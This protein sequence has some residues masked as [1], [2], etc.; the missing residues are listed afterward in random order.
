MEANETTGGAVRTT[1]GTPIGTVLEGRYQVVRPLARGGMSSVYAGIDLRLD[2][3]VAIK[4]MESTYAADP[5]F[6]ERFNGEARA[7]ARLDHTHVVAVHDQGV[8]R[9]GDTDR[10]YLVM[11]LVD[12][13]TLRDL[14]RAHRALPVPLTMAILEQ[15]LSALADAHA[16]GLVH[17]D[18]KPENVLIGHGSGGGVVKVA[19]FGLVRAIASARST[20]DNVVLGTVAYL[21]PEQL[22]SGFADAHSDVYATGIMCYEMLTGHPPYSADTGLGVAYRHVHDDVPAPSEAVPDIPA[23]LDDLV[24]RATRRDP[25][26]RPADA[27]AF[28]SDL[29]RIRDQLGIDRVPVPVPEWP[30]PNGDPDTEPADASLATVEVI[31]ETI[32]LAKPATAPPTPPADATARVVPT[33]P[34]SAGPRGT[35]AISRAE[36]DAALR[37][38]PPPTNPEPRHAGDGYYEQRAKGRRLSWMW[39]VIILLLAAIIGGVAWWLGIGQW[40]SVPQVAGQDSA[41]AERALTAADLNPQFTQAY[42]NTVPAGRVVGTT[43][44]VGSRALRGAKVTLLVSEGRPVVPDVAPG[45]QVAAVEQAIRSLGLQPKLD[46]NANTYDNTV[47]AGAV[48]KVVPSPGTPVDVGS[49]VTISVSEGPPP[50]PVPSVAGMTQ[51]AAF[52]ALTQAGYQPYTLPAQFSAQVDGG[53]VISTSPGAGTVIAANGDRRVGVVLSNAVT[54]PNVTGAKVS[55][56]QQA[57]AAVGLQAQVQELMSGANGTVLSQ[58]APP[59]TRVTAGTAITI[60]AFP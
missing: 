26:Q 9:S 8:D 37:S 16:A 11:E 59:G 6:V 32:Q 4:I 47:P 40:T 10:V 35:R 28:R 25:A 34:G 19:D 13:G 31:G 17:R 15:V 33:P 36:L 56:A 38:A 24:L 54:V 51:A 49:A 57:L 58:S 42:N 12:G 22:T 20:N 46:P 52:A 48:L 23:E 30:D 45:A 7:A 1:A 43:P 5:A 41:S 60:T 21:S 29:T 27:S 39:L 50:T 18:V 55:D 2:R 53:S 3:P 14:L 44:S